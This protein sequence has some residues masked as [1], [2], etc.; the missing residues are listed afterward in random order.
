MY[1]VYQI[2]Y[3]DTLD[4]ISQKSETPIDELIKLNGEFEVIPG[5]T[6]AT[7]SASALGAPLHD[8]AI[9]SLS[10]LLT[11]LEEIQRKI[12]YAAIADLVIAFYN[13]KSKTRTEPFETACDI[14]VENRNPE[15]PV[16][17]VKTEEVTNSVELKKE[18]YRI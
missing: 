6:A 7:Y 8:L 3:G 17:I 14:L 9:I 16:G 11:P 2:E 5:V 18:V 12:K 10:D 1:K 4:I 15:T 13:P